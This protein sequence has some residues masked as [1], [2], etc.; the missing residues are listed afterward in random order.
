MLHLLK[1]KVLFVTGFVKISKT[2][3][4]TKHVY[5]CLVQSTYRQLLSDSGS[6]LNGLGLEG[7][8]RMVALQ[9]SQGCQFHFLPLSNPK[10]HKNKRLS[11]QSIRRER[12][13]S[14]GWCQRCCSRTERTV[15]LVFGCRVRSWLFIIM[16]EYHPSIV[17]VVRDRFPGVRSKM[18]G[19]SH[20]PATARKSSIDRNKKCVS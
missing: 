7:E 18:H 5:K 13:G 3:P 2:C 14:V 17:S 12:R 20:I 19:N 16:E 11:E 1:R 6:T 9:I 8:H 10:R 15:L 4:L